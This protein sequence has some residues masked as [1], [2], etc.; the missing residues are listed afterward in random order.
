MAAKRRRRPQRK[1]VGKV[2]YFYHHGSWWVYYLDG[3]RQV[4]RR[5]G[6][7]EKAAEAIAAQVNAQLTTAAP[8]MFS[9]TPLTVPELNHQFLD[10]HE[11]VLRSSVATIRRYR[12][13]LKHLEDFANR[14]RGLV[15]AH[16]I[17]ADRFIRYLRT[18]DVAPNGHKNATK[19]KLRD[20]GVLFILEV[21]RNLYTFAAKKRHLP[22]YAENPFTTLA[23]SRFQ[24]EDAKRIFVFDAQTE[25]TFLKA[26]GAWDF[27]IFFTL[28]K[29][30]VRSGELIHLLIEDLD[31]DGGW[32]HIRDKPDLGW[33]VKTR[34]ERSIPLVPELVAIL[35]HVV[36]MRQAGP[37]FVRELFDANLAPLA[38][39]TRQRM[40]QALTRRIE[41]AER[42]PGQT[43]DRE[44][45]AAIAHSVW[46]D[47]GAVKAD[48][49][50][51]LFI[52]AA[53][54]AGLGEA[55][56]PKSFRHS[57][58]TLLQDANVD[59]LIRQITLGHSSS[60]TAGEALG[61]TSIY[62]HTRPETQRQEILRAVRLWPES[63]KL[64]NQY[65]HGMEPWNAETISSITPKHHEEEQHHG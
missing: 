45:K 7:D 59:P 1:R 40:V 29:S 54:I 24:I 38:G 15:Q 56:C 19:R 3:E 25:L 48:R 10:H 62:T 58:A 18:I 57:F 27:P 63:L 20:K 49:I 14:V 39:A 32:M 61:M 17:D 37:V 6:P 51:L 46:R 50:R 44:A 64:A 4:R 9:F 52:R 31:L 42:Q 30:G 28:A 2:S 53:G 65:L 5:T 8:T 23:G 13:A 21:C 36:G 16:Q 11:H 43:L 22:P 34:R 55:T 26:A 47:A 33:R 35:R 41:Q 12:T 60:G